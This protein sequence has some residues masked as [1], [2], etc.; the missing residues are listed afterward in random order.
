MLRHM[1][2]LPYSHL[3]ET[4]DENFMFEFHIK[5]FMLADKYDCPSLRSAAVSNFCQCLC[6]CTDNLSNGWSSQD[7]PDPPTVYKAIANI[8]GPP[9]RLTADLSLRHEVSKFCALNYHKMFT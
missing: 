7:T 1:Y 2:N 6:R 5:V 8:C 3:P 9:A 4:K